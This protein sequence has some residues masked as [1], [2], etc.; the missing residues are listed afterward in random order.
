MQDRPPENGYSILFFNDH[1][2]V[3]SK[4]ALVRR[5]NGHV[6]SRMQRDIERISCPLVVAEVVAACP[7]ICQSGIHRDTRYFLEGFGRRAIYF[8]IDDSSIGH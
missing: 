7:S 3:D 5:N 8:D 1:D 6:I 4:P 2:V